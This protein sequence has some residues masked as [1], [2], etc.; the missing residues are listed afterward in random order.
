MVSPFD[1]PPR[2]ASHARSGSDAN[3]VR[4]VP[5]SPPQLLDSPTTDENPFRDVA[6]S[7]YNR[8]AFPT[9]SSHFLPPPKSGTSFLKESDPMARSV[10]AHVSD[11][12][13]VESRP[14]SRGTRDSSARSFL[15]NDGRASA[16]SSSSRPGQRPKSPKARRNTLGRKR[17]QVRVNPDKT[18][19]VVEISDQEESSAQEDEARSPSIASPSERL[20]GT[21]S[22]TNN[23]LSVSTETFT[24]RTRSWQS[25]TTVTTVTSNARS[26]TSELTIRNVTPEEQGSDPATPDAELVGG[27]RR[28][29]N[30]PDAKGKQPMTSDSQASPPS[31]SEEFKRKYYLS[32]KT[33]FQSENSAAPSDS[34][35]GQAYPS[36][37]PV[38]ATTRRHSSSTSSNEQRLPSPK[39]PSSNGSYG[40]EAT[41]IHHTI[42]ASSS[43]P[44]Y[45]VLGQTSPAYSPT[46]SSYHQRRVTL[47]LSSDENYKILG[48]TSPTGSGSVL[49]RGGSSAQSSEQN[50]VVHG[51]TSPGSSHPVSPADLSDSNFEFSPNPSLLQLPAQPQ[52]TYSRESLVIPPLQPR[53]QR[54][55]EG[56]GYYKQHSRESLRSASQTS[57]TPSFIDDAKIALA[58]GKQVARIP[59]LNNIPE[60]GSWLGDLGLT[61]L[62]KD[63]KRTDSHQWTPELSTVVSMSD[64]MASGEASRQM[65]EGF[66]KSSA[67]SSVDTDRYQKSS[68]VPLVDNRAETDSLDFPQPSYNLNR[69]HF[70][71]ST[72]RLIDDHDE[73]DDQITE[74]PRLHERPSRTRLSYLSS[75]YAYT[76]TGRSNSIRSFGSSRAGSMLSNGIPTWA[77]LY[78]GSG[79]Q[80]SIDAALSSR[81]ASTRRNSSDRSRSPDSAYIPQAIYS[82]RRR[83]RENELHPMSAQHSRHT[84]LQQSIRNSFHSRHS[85][86]QRSHLSVQHSREQSTQSNYTQSIDFAPAPPSKSE[87]QSA[88]SAPSANSKV[89]IEQSFIDRMRK[90]SSVWSPHLQLDK[91]AEPRDRAWEAHS[92]DW[93]Q[94]GISSR[95]NMQVMLFIAGF[96]FPISWMVA[97]FLPLPNRPELPPMTEEDQRRSRHDILLE[98]NRIWSPMDEQRYQSARWWRILNRIFSVAGVVIIVVIV[99]LVVTR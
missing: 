97:S 34:S 11:E 96:I 92:V 41:V 35:N 95:R 58:A 48:Q 50:Y 3:A 27:I 5:P 36:S 30:S 13:A 23:R 12:K 83:P 74:I 45:E 24:P 88:R 84:S 39:L 80:R 91:R 7:V 61:P 42:S 79:E 82:A 14:P 99:V 18:F 53:P 29:E 68:S 62:P 43:N 59:S 52:P 90:P 93:S 67:I 56:F 21:S 60:S 71:D 72:V 16:A 47:P 63:E 86:L 94:S 85:S 33:S 69:R 49:Q 44:N 6:E 73:G 20:S 8:S 17:K 46:S 10:A 98:R 57:L 78:Y 40:E 22:S 76:D 4:I 25:G 75:P 9:Q 87:V 65:S 64:Q 37:P 28:V 55:S 54:S 31:I 1:T 32:S 51:K 77:R 2:N 19:S 38:F 66:R 70:S 26:R 15:D 81:A 89:D